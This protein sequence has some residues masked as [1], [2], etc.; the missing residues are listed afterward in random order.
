M[1]VHD[2]AISPPVLRLP[3]S[4]DQGELQSVLGRARRDTGHARCA[5]NGSDVHELI[6]G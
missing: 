6:N 2:D 4:R 3:F 5:F 1:R